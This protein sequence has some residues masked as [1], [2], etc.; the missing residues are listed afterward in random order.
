MAAALAGLLAG[1]ACGG[2]GDAGGTAATTAPAT[3]SATPT[4]TPTPT[5]GQKAT[6][7]QRKAALL[8]VEDMPTGWSIDEDD[9]DDSGPFGEGCAPLTALEKK[10]PDEGDDAEIAFTQGELGPLF[11]EEVSSLDTADE[12]STRIADL[13]EALGEC[14]SFT[15]KDDRGA[16]QRVTIAPVS[17]P[18][19]GDESFAVRISVTFRGGRLGMTVVTARVRNHVL[20]MTGMTLT[21]VA[22]SS[23]LPPKELEELV[24]KAVEKATTTLP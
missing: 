16:T 24:G 12:V 14:P 18:T 15:Y 2:D 6:A 21:T 5:G 9:D 20:V 19:V 10:Y 17:F 8:T 13:K 22:G 7:E 4:P 11:G 1:T 23:Q 3:T